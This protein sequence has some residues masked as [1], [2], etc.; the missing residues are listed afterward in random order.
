M[1]KQDLQDKIDIEV[2]RLSRYGHDPKELEQSFYRVINEYTKSLNESL[3]RYKD[4]VSSGVDRTQEL[5][6][7]LV[8]MTD[9]LSELDSSQN[10][11]EL[12]LETNNLLD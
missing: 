4:I 2:R 3:T 5:R 10:V 7:A 12:I 8:K 11:Q 1:T 9:V 6:E